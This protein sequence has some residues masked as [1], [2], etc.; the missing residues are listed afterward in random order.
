M[1]EFNLKDISAA[2][3]GLGAQWAHPAFMN[4][5]VSLESLDEYC[6]AEANNIRPS[7]PLMPNSI[8]TSVHFYMGEFCSVGDLSTQGT[9]VGLPCNWT[10]TPILTNHGVAEQPSGHNVVR[11]HFDDLGHKPRWDKEPEVILGEAEPCRDSGCIS[12]FG[13]AVD[14]FGRLLVSSDTTNE[15]FMVSRAY[16]QTAVKLLT[17]RA[18]AEDDK[19]DSESIL[20]DSEKSESSKPDDDKKKGSKK[21]DD[22]EE[23]GESKKLDDDEEKGGSKKKDNDE[24]KGG[25]KKKDN[26]DEEK[27]ES[28]KKDNDDEEK[29]GSK[30]K[31]NDEEKGGS[32]KKDND[33][34]KEKDESKKLD[35]DKKKESK[36]SD[37]EKSG[38]K[39][40]K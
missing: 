26:D 31:D 24:E 12:P 16:N 10:D 32:K 9:S 37:E 1:T 39:K 23:K 29:S 18:N 22:D 28:K 38:S 40:T 4:D 17:D 19:D 11:L 30:K 5:S 3:K 21:S 25:S 8:A 13:L 14:N 34:L 27:D 20:D 33:D 7:V 35:D 36:K 6:Q 15:V 2:S